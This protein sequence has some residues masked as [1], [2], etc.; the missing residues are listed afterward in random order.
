[1]FNFNALTNADKQ[2]LTFIIRQAYNCATFEHNNNDLEAECDR[3]IDSL[4]YDYE[5]IEE[6]VWDTVL[7][8]DTPIS[9]LG[10]TELEEAFAPFLDME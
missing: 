8:C 7:G 3:L 1:M 4:D 6:V 2:E 5:E 10:N 9:R